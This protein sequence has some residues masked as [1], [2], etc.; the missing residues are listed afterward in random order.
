MLFDMLPRMFPN[1]SRQFNEEEL[2]KLGTAMLAGNP[3]SGGP[4]A[5]YTY[6]GQFIAHDLTQLS[7]DEERPVKHGSEPIQERNPALDLD[8]VYGGLDTRG[9]IIAVEPDGSMKV[10][11]TYSDTGQWAKSDLPRDA[12]GMPLIPD[13]RNEDNLFVAQIHVLFLRLHNYLIENHGAGINN[14]SDRFKF[15]KENTIRI[16]HELIKTDFLSKI[17][18]ATVYDEM[19]IQG[20]HLSWNQ[21]RVPREFA[22]AAFRFGHAMV[23]NQY[24]P[25]ANQI[26]PLEHFLTMTGRHRFSR[27]RLP[28]LLE[29][30]RIDWRSMFFDW[31]ALPA[32][33][34][35]NFARGLSPIINLKIKPTGD[36]PE[37]NIAKRNLL[38]GNELELPSGQDIIQAI[39]PAIKNALGI[40][41]LTAT[42]LNIQNLLDDTNL[43]LQTPLWYYLLA[44]ADVIGGNA[45]LGPLGSY[46][47]ADVMM[48]LLNNSP[49]HGK[50]VIPPP[51]GNPWTMNELVWNVLP[52]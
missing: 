5:G 43:G 30:E 37:V 10:D 25:R 4:P 45:K 26:R 41:S 2:K 47:V 33:L 12:N 22:G 44:E 52:M 11:L 24:T 18:D 21:L 17:L 35:K 19:V 42:Q 27:S 48:G 20:N 49:H 29:S 50:A 34:E 14:R 39:A 32:G 38:R 9:F 3:V 13:D 36:F 40:N 16:Y 23:L 7:T 51:S 1:L 46:L 8:P 31:G 28:G 15:G 6:F